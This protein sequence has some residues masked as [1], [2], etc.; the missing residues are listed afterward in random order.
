MRYL[1]TMTIDVEEVSDFK[2]R[3]NPQADLA[4]VKETAPSKEVNRPSSPPSTSEKLTYGIK[5]AG[6][7]LGVGRTFLYALI[8]DG[9]LPV[10]KLKRRTLIP[11]QALQILLDKLQ[12]H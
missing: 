11:V 1:V 3:K 2:P 10:V 8:K 12:R 5:E 4:K 9:T 6:V 7:V